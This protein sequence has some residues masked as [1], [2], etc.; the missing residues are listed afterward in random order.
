MT[1]LIQ[2][3]LRYLSTRGSRHNGKPISAAAALDRRLH[4]F[5]TRPDPTESPVQQP[6]RS[7][8][9]HGLGRSASAIAQNCDRLQSR[10]SLAWTMVI[11]PSP[12]L[13]DALPNDMV[14]DLLSTLTEDILDHYY[15]ERQMPTPPFSYVYHDKLNQHGQMQ[16]H[17]HVILPGRLPPPDNITL[18][19]Y[20][21][22]LK[23]LHTIA[24]DQFRSHLDY[25]LGFGWEFHFGPQYD[26]TT[27]GT[28]Y[29]PP[30][31]MTD[32]ALWLP[33]PSQPPPLPDRPTLQEPI[34]DD[35]LP[36]A[37]APTRKRKE[38]EGPD[39]TL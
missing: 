1:S 36:N 38:D 28:T 2:T 14:P 13:I 15:A 33:Q 20:P 10:H 26:F 24:N 27:P 30:V 22:D 23:L 39:L 5:E 37:I 18:T 9:D 17:T 19:H 4:Y 12:V 6:V 16:P 31:P 34:D 32:L 11:T 35:W 7:W 3:P 29:P 25:Q 21:A 8:Y